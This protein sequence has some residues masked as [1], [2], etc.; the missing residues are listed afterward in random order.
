VRGLSLLAV[1]MAGGGG[2]RADG[3]KHTCHAHTRTLFS[4]SFLPPDPLVGFWMDV[5]QPPD[6]ITGVGLFLSFMRKA[7]PEQLA[8]A[9]DGYD[10][11][12]DVMVVSASCCIRGRACLHACG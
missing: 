3:I 2:L 6:Y 11:V 9:K 7:H 5:G 12:G 4:P 10:I 1:C 8:V